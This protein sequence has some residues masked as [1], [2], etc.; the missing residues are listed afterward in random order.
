MFT[1]LSSN[2]AA[3]VRHIAEQKRAALINNR[4]EPLVI[5]IPRVSTPSAD[6][7]LRPEVKRLLLQPIVINVAGLRINLVRKISK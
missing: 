2:E 7:Q 1:H 6:N 5:P 4:S 3:N